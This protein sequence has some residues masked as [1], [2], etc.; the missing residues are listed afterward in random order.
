[1][2]VVTD[3]VVEP[4]SQLP[5]CVQVEY[6]NVC[7]FVCACWEKRKQGVIPLAAHTTVV[8]FLLVQVYICIIFVII[9]ESRRCIGFKRF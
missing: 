3:L 5:V 7:V 1:M 2:T 6:I 8:I 4:Y 9:N